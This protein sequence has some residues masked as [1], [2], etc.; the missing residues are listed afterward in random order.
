MH[1]GAF[2]CGPPGKYG[3]DEESVAMLETRTPTAE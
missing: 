1:L 2:E 3:S